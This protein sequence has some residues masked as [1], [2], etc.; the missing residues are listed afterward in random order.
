VDE[1]VH[2]VKDEHNMVDGEKWTLDSVLS[3]GVRTGNARVIIRCIPMSFLCLDE[4][5]SS[6]IFESTL[7]VIQ[8]SHHTI[9]CHNL[10]QATVR[11]I[12]HARR[13]CL[14]HRTGNIRATFVLTSKLVSIM[15]RLLAADRHVL[16]R[17][18]LICII[19]PYKVRS[20]PLV[21]T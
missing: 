1:G 18:Q 12:V 9:V 5:R 6:N 16:P 2:N 10:V 13:Q 17:C 8:I 11:V 21:C 7:A 3:D 15:F 19:S 14:K 20:A 4:R